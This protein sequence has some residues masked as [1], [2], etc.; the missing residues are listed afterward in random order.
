MR[1]PQGL[2]V[3][4]ELGWGQAFSGS[5]R[6]PVPMDLSDEGTSW[7]E[8]SETEQYQSWPRLGGRWP[9]IYGVHLGEDQGPF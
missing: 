8:G 4:L 2:E 5:N 9:H 6:S 3:G 7:A 1:E